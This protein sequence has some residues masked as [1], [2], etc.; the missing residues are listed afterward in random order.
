MPCIFTKSAQGYETK[1]LASP[2]G[3]KILARLSRGTSEGASQLAF[4]GSA[5]SCTQTGRPGLRSR[6]QGLL[7]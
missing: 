1:E 6:I 5:Q 2:V 7:E 3:S 4:F